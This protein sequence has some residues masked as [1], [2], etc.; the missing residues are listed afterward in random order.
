MELARLAS[1]SK[2]QATS[3]AGPFLGPRATGLP[4]SKKNNVATL[5]RSLQLSRERFFFQSD[6]H[7]V[8]NDDLVGFWPALGLGHL[9][10]FRARAENR[11]TQFPAAPKRKKKLP[12]CPGWLSATFFTFYV[13]TNRTPTG[14]KSQ[15]MGSLGHFGPG[16]PLALRG[17]PG[18]DR[19]R[20]NTT[21]R[22]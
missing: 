7:V 14:R 2:Q 11:K 19:K 4:K 17:I 20:K 9:E 21:S 5:S 13:L 3:P 6:P 10:K 1:S 12:R 18:P 15:N 22:C 16:R 8:G